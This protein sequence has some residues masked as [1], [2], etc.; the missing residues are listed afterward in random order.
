MSNRRLV[1]D[2]LDR[3]MAK[4]SIVRDLNIPSVGWI[5]SIRKAVRMSLRQ[6]GKRLSISAPSA[7]DIEKREASGTISI[8]A[9]RK[10]G[11]ALDLE[12]VYGFVPRAGTLE[13]MIEERAQIIAREIVRRTSV[14]MELED[15]G[16]SSSRLERA[17]REKTEEIKQEM[18]RYLWD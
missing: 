16:N 6:L 15:Q 11:A 3:K 18:P 4:L 17:L 8:N 5:R 7:R 14:N 10:A 2:H 9:L 12:L 1:V 13:K